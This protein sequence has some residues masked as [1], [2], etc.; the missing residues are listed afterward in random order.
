MVP[1]I[2]G[3]GQGNALTMDANTVGRAQ[4]DDDKVGAGFNDERMVAADTRVVQDNVIVGKPP[5]A[6]GRR[7]EGIDLSRGG[8]Q[9]RSSVL[10]AYSAAQVDVGHGEGRRFLRGLFE[11]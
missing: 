8:V 11:V 2:K 1:L 10:L 5:D 7:V 6:G 9:S 4:I 3:G